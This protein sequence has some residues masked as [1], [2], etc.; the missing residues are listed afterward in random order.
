[1]VGTGAWLVVNL[2]HTAV[3]LVSCAVFVGVAVL[4]KWNWRIAGSI[5]VVIAMAGLLLIDV[6]AGRFAEMAPIRFFP[7]FAVLAMIV[8]T[9]LWPRR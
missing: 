9:N 2:L 6:R 8:L 5:G 7:G 4:A 1:M 3:Y